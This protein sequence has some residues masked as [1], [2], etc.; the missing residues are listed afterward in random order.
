MVFSAVG[1]WHT[2]GAMDRFV[3]YNAGGQGYDSGGRMITTVAT[4]SLY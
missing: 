2:I 4:G 1:R 3:V